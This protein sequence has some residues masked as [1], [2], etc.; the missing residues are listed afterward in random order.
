MTTLLRSTFIAA[1]ALLPLAAQPAPRGPRTEGFQQA[2]Q[3][4]E[5]QR[6]S[7]RAIREKRRPDLTAKR[8]A[9]QHARIDLR[10]ALQDLSIPEARLRALYDKASAA[11]FELVLARRA[12]RL[13]LRS[14]LTPE[15]QARAAEMRHLARAGAHRHQSRGEDWMAR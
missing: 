14:V 1:L 13:E 8:D 15:Q 7:L 2:L 10:S 9:V 12:L 4:T 6:T 3:L 11:R 5:A